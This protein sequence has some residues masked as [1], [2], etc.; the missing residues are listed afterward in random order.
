MTLNHLQARAYEFLLVKK[1]GVQQN[2]GLIQFNRPRALNA[3]CVELMKEVNEALDVFES[4]DIVKSIVITGSEKAFAAGADIKEMHG[5]P[6][7]EVYRTN[8]LSSW[9]RVALHRKP[10]IAAVC[11]YALGGGCELAMM[12]DIIYASDTAKFGQ[13]E[14]KLGTIPGAGGTQRLIRAI[15]KSRAMELILTGDT[16]TAQEAAAA[17]LVSRVFPA[18]DVLPK[19]IE[20]G[21]KIGRFS[22][23]AVQA[24]KEAI[25]ACKK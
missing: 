24:A 18:A 3:L 11:G 25:N 12:C 17:G 8:F 15:G 23:L 20:L 7:S 10:I 14:I 16:F 21:D 9:N 13:P 22:G 2:V 5:R 4:D 19:A 1:T 6:Y